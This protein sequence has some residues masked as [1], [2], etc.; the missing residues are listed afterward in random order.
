MYRPLVSAALSA[1]LLAAVPA[2]ADAKHYKGR[3]SQGRVVTLR[4]GGDGVVN[5]VQI[6]WRAPCG[7]RIVYNGRTGWR[8]SFDVATGDAVQDTGTYRVRVRGG[9]RA[10]ITTTLVGQRNPA[11]DRWA[12]TL[13]VKVLVARRGKVVDTCQLKRL[14]WTAR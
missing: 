9:F 8:P 10:R 7:Q 12:G 11:A 2:V 13:A 1:L 5:R 14:R 6:G 3:S 4:T